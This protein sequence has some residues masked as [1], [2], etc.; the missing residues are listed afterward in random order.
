MLKNNKTLFSTLLFIGLISFIHFLFFIPT[1]K[2]IS[3]AITPLNQTTTQIIT[4]TPVISLPSTVKTTVIA[5]DQASSVYLTDE[6]F[7]VDC[8]EATETY[9]SSGDTIS[10]Q[11]SDYMSKLS[12][13]IKTEDKLAYLIQSPKKRLLTI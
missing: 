8:T 13:S 9:V 7:I 10:N 2:V 11:L 12:Q 3:P 5:N 6:H 1:S 4:N